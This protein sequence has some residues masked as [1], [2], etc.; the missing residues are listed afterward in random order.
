V[1]STG[2]S[3]DFDKRQ[4]ETKMSGLRQININFD[5]V[6]DRLLLRIT[7]GDPGNIDEF[8][9]WLTRRLIQ[10]LWNLSLG[11]VPGKSVFYVEAP[12]TLN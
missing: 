1:Q 11:M 12:R 3:R 2:S 7:A 8:R 6:E 5:P 4:E 9:I 10:I